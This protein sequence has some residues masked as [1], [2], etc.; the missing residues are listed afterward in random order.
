MV[1]Y[2]EAPN[3]HISLLFQCAIEATEEA[4]YNSLCMAE[5][6]MGYKGK[7]VYV[8]LLDRLQEGA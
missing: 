6:M 5:A 4:I 2:P 8:L 7:T 3:A 1:W